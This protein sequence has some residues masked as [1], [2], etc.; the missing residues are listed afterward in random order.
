MDKQVTVR[1]LAFAVA[2]IMVVC[3]GLFGCFVGA[4]LFLWAES[5][6]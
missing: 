6:K 3:G 1:H 4:G 2:A 5:K